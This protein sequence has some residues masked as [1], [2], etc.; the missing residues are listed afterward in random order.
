MKKLTITIPEM[1][2]GELEE[3][4]RFQGRSISNLASFLIELGALNWKEMNIQLGEED[5]LDL[6][7]LASERGMS[8]LAL[9]ESILTDY[10]RSVKAREEIPFAIRSSEDD[11]ERNLEDNEE[12]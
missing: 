1:L 4:A 3:M 6:Q 2:Y 9:V 11:T 7:A 10:L 12:E 8:P 5:S